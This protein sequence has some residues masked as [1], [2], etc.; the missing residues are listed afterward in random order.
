MFDT[1]HYLLSFMGAAIGCFVVAFM[2]PGSLG[3]LIIGWQIGVP[4]GIFC[5]VLI[6]DL[7]TTGIKS[8]HI[9][10]LLLSFIVNYGLGYILYILMHVAGILGAIIVLLLS[11]TV[12]LA[13]YNF[14][15]NKTSKNSRT[16]NKKQ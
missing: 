10:G 16:N 8:Y 5:G 15:K 6:A 1:K 12:C 11:I 13:C 4:L 2:G 9:V 3:S 14:M 7:P